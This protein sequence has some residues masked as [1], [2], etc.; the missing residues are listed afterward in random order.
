[1]GCIYISVSPFITRSY[2]WILDSNY[3]QRFY[4]FEQTHTICHLCNEVLQYVK[5][6]HNHL[7]FTHKMYMCGG[8]AVYYFESSIC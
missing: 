4:I 5:I 2:Y 3:A 8:N 6:Y 1:M 7:Y